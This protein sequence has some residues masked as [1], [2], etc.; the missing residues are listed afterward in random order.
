VPEWFAIEV[1]DSSM[2]SARSWGEAWRDAIVAAAVEHG[3]SDWEVRE[4]D[5]G[6]V[7]ELQLPDDLAWMRLLTSA[8]IRAALDAVPDPVRGLSIH[9]GRG[10]SAGVADPRR[11]RPLAGAGAVALPEP[12]EPEIPVY[13]AYVLTGS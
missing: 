4:L 11:P 1:S 12:V 3:L 8:A 13:A 10:G 6:V 9:R 7:V 5:W 2:A